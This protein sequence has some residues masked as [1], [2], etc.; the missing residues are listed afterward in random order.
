M[1]IDENLIFKDGQPVE[2]KEEE[3]VEDVTETINFGQSE[4]T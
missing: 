2:R 1:R 4:D 3:R